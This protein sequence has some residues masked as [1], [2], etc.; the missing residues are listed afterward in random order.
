[1]SANT[2]RI[3]LARGIPAWHNENST[4]LPDEAMDYDTIVRHV[5]QIGMPVAPRQLFWIGEGG[6]PHLVPDNVANVR[7]DGAYLG[8]VGDGYQAVQGKEAFG[9][10]S[11]LLRPNGDGEREVIADTAGTLAGGRKLFIACRASR[12]FYVAGQEDEAHTGYLTFLNSYD[13]STKV[14]AVI[15]T[16][17][18]VCENTF[19][20]NLGSHKASYFFR[21]TG[22]V[23]ARLEEARQA[24]SV[25][26]RYWSE[27]ERRMNALVGAPF[28]GQDWSALLD[29]L[30]TPGHKVAELPAK[31]RANVER[32]R[33]ELTLLWVGADDV[34]NVRGTAYAALQACTAWN[35]HM[36]RGR[37]SEGGT[38]AENRTRRILLDA[39]FKQKAV[40]RI[41]EMAEVR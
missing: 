39:S 21:H 2:E 16:V 41:C 24:L 20:A 13:A 10:L 37:K 3:V 11:A 12:Q 4:V 8:I 23:M 25:A 34:Q 31:A 36:V 32:E 19:N 5:P 7:E 28:S 35:D 18:T 15:S 29:H 9:F 38:I 14:G 30:T 33:E 40:D 17:R 1:M 22:S 26:G 27:Y 6:V